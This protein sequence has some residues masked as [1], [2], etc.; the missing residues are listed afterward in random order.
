MITRDF[1]IAN[2]V[3]EPAEMG[4]TFVLQPNGADFTV[5]GLI[6]LNAQ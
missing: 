4:E 3:L 6:Y 2:I 1:N 5:K